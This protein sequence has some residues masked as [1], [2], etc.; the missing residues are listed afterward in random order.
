MKIRCDICGREFVPGRGLSC[1]RRVAHGVARVLE[2]KVAAEDV[3]CPVGCGRM[4]TA[5]GVTHHANVCDGTTPAQRAAARVRPLTS[6]Q[7]TELEKEATAAQRAQAFA[8]MDAL[9]PLDLRPM[10]ER[11]RVRQSDEPVF[12][13]DTLRRGVAS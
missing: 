7:R 4:F 12:I 9:G 2:P 10:S 5:R 8:L 6:A 3:L 11:P 13:S 1:H